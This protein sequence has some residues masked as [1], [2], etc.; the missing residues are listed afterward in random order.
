[1]NKITVHSVK[2]MPYP[3]Y[4]LDLLCEIGLKRIPMTLF[5][6]EIIDEKLFSY[7]VIKNEIVFGELVEVLYL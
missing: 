3:F 1:M 6:F 7:Y 5:S 4:D 2:G